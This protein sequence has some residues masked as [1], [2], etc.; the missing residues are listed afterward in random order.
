MQFKE[1]LRDYTAP[2]YRKTSQELLLGHLY[3]GVVT[4]NPNTQDHD[5]I[6][7]VGKILVHELLHAIAGRGVS[8]KIIERREEYLWNTF[9]SD[10]RSYFY[11][12]LFAK[13]RQPRRGIRIRATIPK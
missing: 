6:H 11:I 12:C 13:L 10:Q 5:G 3:D 7:D 2:S 9:S 4:I 8:E 1:R